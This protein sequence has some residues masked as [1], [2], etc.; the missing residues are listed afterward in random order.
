MTTMIDGD[1]RVTFSPVEIAIFYGERP[2]VPKQHGRVER[3]LGP[4]KEKERVPK[5]SPE[6]AR[7]VRA[8]YLLR[9]PIRVIS[10][11]LGVPETT[12]ALMINGHGRYSAAGDPTDAE[13]LDAGLALARWAIEERDK[14]LAST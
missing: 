1:G 14:R 10:R 3:R 4:W 12:C 7:Q 6:K 5:W 9:A 2:A 13:V 8:L 11:V